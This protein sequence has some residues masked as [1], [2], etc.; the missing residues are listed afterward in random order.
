MATGHNKQANAF[1]FLLARRKVT[2]V[3]MTIS[4]LRTA[5][6]ICNQGKRANTKPIPRA[7]AFERGRE[8][9]SWSAI[10]TPRAAA[11]SGYTWDAKV[12][13]GM[14]KVTAAQVA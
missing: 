11:T 14:V 4:R 8:R 1:Q 3:L 12:H 7:F 9:K 2:A 6:R 10:A 13:I 5:N